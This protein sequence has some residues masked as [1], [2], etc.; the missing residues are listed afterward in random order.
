MRAIQNFME[1]YFVPVAAKF[2]SM[3]VL[4]AIRDAFIGTM[5]AT[6][7]GS[8]A[9]MINAIIR[10]MPSQFI[11][12]YDVSSI[13]VLAQIVQVNGFVW[14]GTLAIAGLIFAISW[15]YNLSRTFDVDPMPGALVSVAALVMGI[16]FAVPANPETGFEGAW[17]WL[18]LSHL[19]S[20]AIFTTMLIGAVAVTVYIILMKKNITIKLPDSVPPAVSK[21]FIAIIPATAGLYVVAILY[22]VFNQVAPSIVAALNTPNAPFTADQGFLVDVVQRVIAQPLLGLSQ[23]YPA[24]AIVTFLVSLLWFF[25]LHGPNVLAPLLD[26]VWGVAQL[27]NVTLAGHQGVEAVNAAIAAGQGEAFAWVRGSFD[28][29]AWFGGSGGTITLIIAIFLF[30]KRADYRAVA[31]LGVGPG[32]FNI[33]EPVMFG[34]PIVLNPIMVIPFVLAPL[35]ATTIGYVATV[36]GLVNPVTQ[37]VIWV[38]PPFLLSFLATL[39]WRAPI[40]TLVSFAASLLIYVPF[41]IAANAQEETAID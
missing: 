3:K 14:S 1:R 4:I 17:G 24:V 23:G 39:D 40:V 13:P 31:K 9:V 32:I 12:G 28:A 2:G 35:V 20:A 19:G 27:S 29:Y 36:T 8:V 15:G 37:Q 30:S 5:P 41:V 21:A 18:R 10:D 16:A 11:E 25:G 7:A 34:L 22:F 33:N 26:G 6:M 38:T